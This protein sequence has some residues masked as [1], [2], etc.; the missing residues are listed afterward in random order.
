MNAIVDRQVRSFDFREFSY[1]GRR[2][3][4]AYGMINLARELY[5]VL[6]CSA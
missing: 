5:R 3:R 4:L 1:L 6:L 2:A